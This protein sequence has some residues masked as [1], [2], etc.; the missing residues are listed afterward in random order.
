MKKILV[1]IIC[2]LLVASCG[3]KRSNKQQDLLPEYSLEQLDSIGKNYVPE[4]G[5]Y[6]GTIT[7]PISSDPDGF[8]PVTVTTA[9]ANDILDYYIFEGLITLDMVTLDYIP[10]I[11][12]KWTTSDD[13][14]IWT[15]L[16]RDDVYF[17]DGVKKISKSK[18]KKLR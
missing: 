6:G 16:M 1:L 9:V 2:G 10:K 5:T 3:K 4:I 11:A 12:K 8:C 18:V 7:I 13:G 15:F 14:L 17:S